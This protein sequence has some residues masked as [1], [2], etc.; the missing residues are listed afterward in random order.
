MYWFILIFQFLG[1]IF[2]GIFRLFGGVFGFIF[3]LFRRGARRR[4]VNR[5]LNNAT[6][7]NESN[8]G[9]AEY[10]N[11][12]I[13]AFVARNGA[14]NIVISGANQEL[15]N[16]VNCA[17]AWNCHR[18]GRGAVVL[19]CGNTSL[20]DLITSTFR[21][22]TGLYSVNPSNPIYDPFVDL[23]RNDISQ[24]ILSSSASNYRIERNGHSYIYGLSEYLQLMGR[25]LCVDSYASCLRDRSYDQLMEMAE[26]GNVSDFVARR[27]HSELA[28]GQMELGNIE[29]YF[30]V[31]KRQG[32]GILA[33]ENSA[34]YA[35]SIKKALRQNQVIVLDI[36]NASNSLLLNVVMQ[37]IRDTISQGLP[38]SL[39]VDSVPL[40][41]SEL[42]EQ[43]FRSFAG[44]CSY[45]YSSQDAYADTQ[46]TSN[47]FDTLVGRANSVVVL[48]H[49]SA[50]ASEKFSEF[51]GEYQRVEIDHTVT[52]G[53]TYQTYGQV[54]PG[55][56]YSNVYHRQYTTRRR[57]EAREISSQDLNH[58]Y[59]KQN[60]ST[61]VVSV[62]CTAG[63][64]RDLLGTPRRATATT[65]TGGRRN[66]W[67]RWLIFALLFLLFPPVAFIYS[68]FICGR[69]GKIVSAILFVAVIVLRI[70]LQNGVI[71]FPSI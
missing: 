26:R 35:I 56:A 24:L 48:Q 70:L 54:L 34:P 13:E 65:Y 71:T 58:A 7:E 14:E 1:W 9:V 67:V 46:S 6:N 41:A 36:G 69:R 44:Q 3:G 37:E 11:G 43:L 33:I 52:D 18:S 23:D 39:I 25:P 20:S 32:Q 66:T 60:T 2:R 16:R 19:H 12:P 59:I 30:N 15:R 50:M 42:L 63:S 17:V 62:Q 28:Q 68:F 21:G 45:V 49:Y 8:R 10:T 40:H 4:T 61:E 31:L 47:V 64:A 22:D 5:F 53:D 27:I 55:S 38:F 29:Q 51:F 57:V